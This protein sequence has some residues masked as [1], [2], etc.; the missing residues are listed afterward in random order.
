MHFGRFRILG[1][2]TLLV[3]VP[4][5]G[6]VALTVP[7]VVNRVDAA[8]QAQRTA[9]AVELAGEVGSALQE[10][11]EERLLS[12]GYLF[13]LVQRPELV[14]Q[15]AKVDDRIDRLHRLDQELSPQLRQALEWVGN[16]D[17]TREQVLARK[18]RPDFIINDFTNVVTP[19]ID[20]LG[21]TRQADLTTAA[22]RQ[23]FALDSVLRTDDMISQASGLLTSAVVTKEPGFVGLFSQKLV[24]LQVVVIRF[25]SFATVPQTELY[26]LAQ[27]S[28][29]SR[30]GRDFFTIA[31]TDPAR[32]VQ[33]LNVQSLFPSLRSV[34]VLGRFLENRIEADVTAAVTDARTTATRTAY[35]VSGLSIAL[36]V[37]VFGLSILMARAVARP[38]QR[39]TVS[40]D[41]IARAA[42]TELERV[43]DDD[44]ADAVRPIR[45]DPVDVQARDE[46]G[47]LAR[48]FERVQA[49]AVQLV[50]RQIAG[51][52]NVAQMFGHVG[53]RTQNLVGRQ[54]SL[55][56]A[57]E[58][59]ETDADRLG[60]LYRLDHM[61]SRLRRNA[62]SLVVL[63]GG[64]G[65]NE[66]M[67]PLPLAEV[68]RLALGE[69]EDYT[70]VD[71]EV[72]EDLVVMPALVAD[73]TLLL[74][75]LME[76]ATSFS[77]PHTRV[78]VAAAG[79]AS[80]GARLAVVDHGLGLPAE[81]L[82]EENARLARRERLDLAPT[83]V[84]GLFVVG[85][86]ARRHGLT[87]NLTDTP[88]GGLTAWVELSP[89]HLLTRP[90]SLPARGPAGAGATEMTPLIAGAAARS[91]PG[92]AQPFDPVALSRATRTL[93]AGRSWNAFQPL[94]RA[95]PQPAV[96]DAES[97][98]E[99]ALDVAFDVPV[100][101]DS[102]GYVVEVPRQRNVP[103]YLDEPADLP[104][105]RAATAHNGLRRRVP[106]AH[107]PEQ[108]QPRVAINPPSAADAVA[109][110]DLVESIEAGVT[111]AQWDV[112]EHEVDWV[113]VDPAAVP[114]SPAPDEAPKLM[115]RTPG[116]TLPDMPPPART[117]APPSPPQQLD[118]DE[119]RAMIEQF[120]Y[121]VAMAMRDAQP[122]P[123]GQPR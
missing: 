29:I 76:N 40:A 4:L 28:F 114:Q 85:R 35:T 121:G 119:A 14:V 88:D 80:G 46:I 36:L 50:E 107:V 94:R 45:L 47:D 75:E 5:L 101:P 108:R 49:T 72:P 13:G 102:P 2:L 42:G 21:L 33:T 20:A 68:V 41:R 32:A 86:L 60:E 59:R 3:L 31:A 122:Q 89:E 79:G 38:L 67:E 120:E 39:L 110:R 66:Y 15:S 44:A 58:R 65:A 100:A 109:A 61:S 24:E 116:A 54:L 115:R 26:L 18:A 62:S 93:E 6:V 17:R 64:A 9:D 12:I 113:P 81:R 117:A 16:L 8:R 92:S 95:E 57:L 78:T 71:V 34:I 10:L 56:D 63:S 51:R 48:A 11:Q 96:V 87:V 52:R 97:W 37:L 83:E 104:Q 25:G 69:I 55:I 84:L 98:S 19:I 7:I 30:A 53:R 106:G 112:V 73:L 91:V 105:R 43:A 123:E 118:P 70:R 77:P 82:A 111:R 103:S 27:E 23:V 22:G 1:K 90:E 74:A 99:P